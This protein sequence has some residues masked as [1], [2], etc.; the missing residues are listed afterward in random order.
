M[1]CYQCFY[2]IKIIINIRFQLIN[3]TAN[4]PTQE[5]ISQLSEEQTRDQLR[6]T[7]IFTPHFLA[8]C[9]EWIMCAHPQSDCVHRSELDRL[10]CQAYSDSVCIVCGRVCIVWAHDCTHVARCEAAGWASAFFQ[11]K[12]CGWVKERLAVF[13]AL[14]LQV[15]SVCRRK[16]VC[17]YVCARVQWP[18]TGWRSSVCLSHRC[19]RWA[20]LTHN[21]SKKIVYN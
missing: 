9:V 10:A 8:Y 13:F 5:S 16:D 19:R 20:G 12:H 18:Q 3:L 21:S 6:F 15:L 14:R 2:S 11:A 4:P 17:M 1:F 7:H